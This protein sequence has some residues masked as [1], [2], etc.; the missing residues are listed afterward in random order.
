MT[1]ENI[2]EA[3]FLKYYCL[4]LTPCYI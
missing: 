1:E 2:H 4:Q 3:S